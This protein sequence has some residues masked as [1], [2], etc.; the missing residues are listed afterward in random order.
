[1]AT[2][3]LVNIGSGY[4]LVTSVLR[5]SLQCNFNEYLKFYSGKL[6]QK[7]LF[8]RFFFI[9]SPMGQCVN[10]REQ[11]GRKWPPFYRHFPMNVLLWKLKFQW[12]SFPSGQIKNNPAL[13]QI[14]AGHRT[15]DKPSLV[16]HIHA[17]TSLVPDEWTYKHIDMGRRTWIRCKVAPVN[18]IVQIFSL[19]CEVIYVNLMETFSAF[20]ALCEG[21]PSVSSGSHKK[22]GNA[23]L[24][25]INT[26]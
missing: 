18:K 3:V 19:V 15:G 21:N 25:R 22:A 2:W 16:T 23:D 20:L 7:V 12:N 6:C 13:V 11:I 9:N 14:M 1:M 17:C 10:I 5:K 24:P 8:S 26:R 4:G